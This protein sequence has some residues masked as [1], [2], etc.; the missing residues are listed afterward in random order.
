MDAA[1]DFCTDHPIVDG[2]K[3]RRTMNIPNIF[4]KV[5]LFGLDYINFENAASHKRVVQKKAAYKFKRSF[6]IANLPLQN[7]IDVN[8]HIF[9]FGVADQKTKSN[10]S[11][12]LFFVNIQHV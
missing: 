11:S 4:Q 1:D 10:S 7:F 6:F 5:S 3:Q 8:E 9:T 12:I 2:Y